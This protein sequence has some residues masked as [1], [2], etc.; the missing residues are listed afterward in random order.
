[1][2]PGPG[3]KVSR[4]GVD[5]SKERR[6]RLGAEDMDMQQRGPHSVFHSRWVGFKVDGGGALA[7]VLLYYLVETGNGEAGVCIKDYY[8]TGAAVERDSPKVAGKRGDAGE[9]VEDMC[10]PC[11]GG[12]GRKFNGRRQVFLLLLRSG[13]L[14]RAGGGRED[15]DIQ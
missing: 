1:M 9:M 2:C 3:E 13:N 5:S 14:C 15:E 11:A 12:C 6:G 10:L 4:E 8:R 7:N